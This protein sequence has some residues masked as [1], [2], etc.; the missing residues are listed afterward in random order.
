MKMRL[1]STRFVPK[2]KKAVIHTDTTS[3][4]K[5]QAREL[6]FAGHKV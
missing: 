3:E 6:T 4:Q 2:A 5:L 1:H